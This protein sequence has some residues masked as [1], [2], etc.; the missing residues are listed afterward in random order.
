MENFHVLTGNENS[1][2]DVCFANVT[3]N[4]EGVAN[5]RYETVRVN[6]IVALGKRNVVCSEVTGSNSG[7]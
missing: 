4:F 7:K 1:N 5:W 6:L 2:V 3:N